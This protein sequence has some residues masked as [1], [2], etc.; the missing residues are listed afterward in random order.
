MDDD[1]IAKIT[2]D[3][4]GALLAQ[5]PTKYA[6]T[7]ALGMLMITGYNLLR[8]IEGDTFVQGW[9]EGALSDL[10]ANPPACELRMPH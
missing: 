9:L 6:K 8:S 10:A 4:M 2:L 5:M 7:E 3:A 1:Q